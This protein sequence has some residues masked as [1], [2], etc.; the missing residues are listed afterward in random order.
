MSYNLAVALIAALDAFVI[1]AAAGVCSIPFLIEKPKTVSLVGAT[2]PDAL[3]EIA[4][5]A[6]A[7]EAAAG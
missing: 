7:F 2:L 1:A 6:P 4:E 5:V 3:P